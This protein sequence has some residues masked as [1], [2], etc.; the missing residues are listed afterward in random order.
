MK[1]LKTGLLCTLGAALV[2][3]TAFAGF[4]QP[5]DVDVDLVNM[6]A[7]GDMVTARTSAADNVF[8]GCGSR[9]IEDGAGG[10]FEFGFCQAEDADTESVTCFT[11]N[12]D[13]LDAMD[14]TSDM[15]YI[16]FSWNDDGQGNLTCSR[17]GFST[18][19]F[20]LGKEIKGN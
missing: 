4:T 13:L 8:I 19:S 2:S 3:A 12:A 17:I 16:T 15:S 1:K 14:S 20:Y 5:A 18:Q 6:F 11:T 9:K 7:Q 10:L